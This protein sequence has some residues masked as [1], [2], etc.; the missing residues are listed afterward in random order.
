MR[1]RIKRM[2]R[3]KPCLLRHRYEKSPPDLRIKGVGA[4]ER[5]AQVAPSFVN[6]CTSLRRKFRRDFNA[7]DSSF[8]SFVFFVRG[9]EGTDEKGTHA[10]P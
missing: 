4:V 9:R 6:R 1:E 10:Q 8:V 2:K 5:G 3:I 7:L